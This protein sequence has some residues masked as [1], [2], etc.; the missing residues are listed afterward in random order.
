ML[1]LSDGLGEEVGWRGFALPCLQRQI[2]PAVA[3][4]LLAVPWA[5]WHLPLFWTRGAS[6]EGRS[7][8]LMLVELIPTSMLFAWV[9]NRSHG[10]VVLVILLHGTQNLAA[11]PPPVAGG[12]L[13]TP[14]VICVA[15]EWLLA[16]AVL[17]LDRRFRAPERRDP[18]SACAVAAG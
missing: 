9:F 14:Y 11:P 13:L 12:T 6:L 7:P 1:A 18:G 4:V 2:W 5:A 10:S 3:A 16:V 17:T 8:A 15:I